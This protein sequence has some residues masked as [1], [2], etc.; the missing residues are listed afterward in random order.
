MIQ[1]PIEVYVCPSARSAS[2]R[3]ANLAYL[4]YKGITGTVSSLPA[5]ASDV[6][7]LGS[8]GVM[9]HNIFVDD[10]DVTDGMS[11]TL[12]F[13]ESRFGLW[14]D[15]AS[16][17]SGVV[18]DQPPFD[19]LIDMKYQPN[20][21]N[22]ATA[23]SFMYFTGFGSYHGDL[24]NFALGRRLGT[25][26]S[27]SSSIEKCSSALHTQRSTN[28]DPRLLKTCPRCFQGVAPTKPSTIPPTAVTQVEVSGT[29]RQVVF[30]SGVRSTRLRRAASASSFAGGVLGQW[31]NLD[32]KDS[33]RPAL[34][35]QSGLIED[36]RQNVPHRHVAE[37]QRD[38]LIQSDPNTSGGSS[39]SRIGTAAI[40]SISRSRS[41]IGTGSFC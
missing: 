1:T 21:N 29:N 3:P 17:A 5:T 19:Y 16:A 39:S 10:R 23:A 18:A 37:R 30:A 6:P 13:A 32:H 22:G 11:T 14:G 7:D 28:A 35:R 15:A 20:G 40:S 26:A 33:L 27:P 41:R 4:T 31:R 24:V 36:G 9:S 12:M 2:S 34:E 38:R 8:N 25:L